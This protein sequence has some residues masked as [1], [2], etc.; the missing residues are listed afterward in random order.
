M[1]FDL[2]NPLSNEN[3]AQISKI[4]KMLNARFLQLQKYPFEDHHTGDV[5]APASKEKTEFYRSFENIWRELKWYEHLDQKDIPD[6]VKNQEGKC[7]K[8]RVYEGGIKIINGSGM[9]V[10]PTE[11]NCLESFM[12][13][14]LLVPITE[15]EYKIYLK[16]NDTD[17]NN[18]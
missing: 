6:Y 7:F 4:K 10:E 5:I 8:V 16:K 13:P 18:G 17:N 12:N 3:V 11:E 2:Y 9:S 1:D 14:D 15:F